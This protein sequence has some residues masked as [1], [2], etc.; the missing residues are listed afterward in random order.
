VTGPL[1]AKGRAAEAPAPA[2]E[3][4]RRDPETLPETPAL[5]AAPAAFDD[6]EP[7]RGGGSKLWIAG[8]ATFG[9]VAVLGMMMLLG[10]G[11]GKVE[12]SNLPADERLYV[13]GVRVD[14]SNLRLEGTQPLIISTAFQG[15]LHRLGRAAPAAGIDVKSLVEVSDPG[16]SEL[17]APL[18]VASDP[19][20]CAV[21]VDGKRL[22]ESTPTK[23][24]LEAGREQLVEVF[25]PGKPSWSQWVMAAPGQALEISASGSSF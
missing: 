20:G 25:C 16:G 24:A 10:R 3:P 1:Q 13:S 17:T 23:V 11:S 2:P 7:S 18:S 21:A 15:R 6:E 9:A 8:G 19:A 22:P 4:K 14:P 12:V 5:V